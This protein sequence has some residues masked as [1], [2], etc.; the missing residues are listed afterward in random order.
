[1]KSRTHYTT[2]QTVLESCIIE[3]VAIG[4]LMRLI[5]GVYTN[6]GTGYGCLLYWPV[7]EIAGGI[8]SISQLTELE[9]SVH[10]VTCW[11]L[12]FDVDW[13]EVEPNWLTKLVL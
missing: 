7:T 12:A 6:A 2:T 13:R 3:C 11:S 9:R 5:V 10:N 1:M 4:G 8:C